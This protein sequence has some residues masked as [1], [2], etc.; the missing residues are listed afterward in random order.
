MSGLLSGSKPNELINIAG[1]S[2]VTCE[3][4]SHDSF[5]AFLAG[6]LSL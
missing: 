3:M 1:M 6:S 2:Q 5:N 4:R